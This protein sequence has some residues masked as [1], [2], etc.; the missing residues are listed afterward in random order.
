M[1]EHKKNAIILFITNDEPENI[2]SLVRFKN[3]DIG[4]VKIVSALYKQMPDYLL[5]SD[6]SVFFIKPVFSK[7]ASSPTKQGEI[8]GMGI[9]LICNNYV[10]DTG[11]IISSTETG[12]V[13]D[14]FNETSYLE[15]IKRIDFLL[16]ISKKKIRDAGEKYYSLEEGIKKYAEVYKAVLSH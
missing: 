6:A 4:S 14:E 3:I 7:M 9:P 2:L 13:V 11:E 8:M 12:F 10:G 15:V 16:Q 1:L 5:V